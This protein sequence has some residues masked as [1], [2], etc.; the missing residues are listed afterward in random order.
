[1]LQKI[2]K[3]N[4]LWDRKDE[5]N[6]KMKFLNCQFSYAAAVFVCIEYA[7]V[8]RVN[9]SAAKSRVAIAKVKTININRFELLAATVGARLCKSVLRALQWDNVKQHY[10]TDSITV[11]GW[12][13]RE[14]LWSVFVNNRVQEI[15]KMT[16]PTFLKNLP[17]AQN[18]ADVP[19]RG[20]SAHQLFSR[21]WEGPKS[22][23]H[24]E[25]NWPVTNP[26]LKNSLF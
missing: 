9:L 12:S 19:S 4:I 22:L 5:D 13:Q 18:P 6:M 21:W 10:W 24:T 3:D 11:L 2:W 26:A 14:E 23:L 1:M 25:E 16:D 17:G 20:C 8:V 15:R 7:D